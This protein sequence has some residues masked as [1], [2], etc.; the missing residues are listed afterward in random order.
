MDKSGNSYTL[1]YNLCITMLSKNECYQWVEFRLGYLRSN[2]LRKKYRFM[3]FCVRSKTANIT[4]IKYLNI[5]MVVPFKEV[6]VSFFFG[7]VEIHWN[8]SIV[9][10]YYWT[11][12]SDIFNNLIKNTK[13]KN[14]CQYWKLFLLSANISPYFPR[15]VI[16]NSDWQFSY[17]IFV[18]LFLK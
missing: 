17:V 2:E 11:H 10:S 13:E 15:H 6:H 18:N 12:Q 9:A 1:K 7:V 3:I 14:Q 4:V 5:Y 16:A 8:I